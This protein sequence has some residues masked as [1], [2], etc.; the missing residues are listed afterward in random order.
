MDLCR[1]YG[2]PD[3]F[4]TLTSNPKWPEINKMLTHVP[5]RHTHD[6]PEVGTRVF[7][8]KLIE[9]LD[10]LTKNKIFEESFAAVYVIEFQKRELPHAHIL[11]WLEDHYKY[12]TLGEIL[13]E[14][15]SPTD[16]LL[17]YKAVTDYM[18]H[19]PC[20]KDVRY[21]LC[22]VEGKC[23]KHFTKPIYEE[24]IIDQ[25]GYPIYRRRDDKPVTL[26]DSECLPALLEME[27]I[28]VTM[29]TDWFV[30]NERHPPV[31]A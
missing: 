22:N 6:R 13:A 3:L 24:T 15:P 20:G 26:R 19:G 16:D 2:N 18:L 28:N 5:G 17:G 23:S 21:A 25:D 9:L 27:G 29:F 30:L 10:D 14:L 1:A 31:R 7:K 12:R 8:L 4:I 11:L